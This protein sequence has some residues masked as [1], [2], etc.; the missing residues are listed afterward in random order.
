MGV[1]IGRIDHPETEVSIRT[2]MKGRSEKGYDGV[3]DTGERSVFVV[4]DTL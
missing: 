4:V 1:K 3:I 2:G